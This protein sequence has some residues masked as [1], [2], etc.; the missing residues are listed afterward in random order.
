MCNLAKYGQRALVGK[1]NMDTESSPDYIESTEESISDT[2]KFIEFVEGMKVLIYSIIT[3]YIYNKESPCQ[4]SYYAKIYT[5][6]LKRID[7]TI[8]TDCKGKVSLYT[9]I[10][11]V[12][13]AV[14]CT[15]LIESF[16]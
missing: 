6:L 5:N 8:S 12:A 16:V 1:V 15:L 2:V 11:I 4:A 9:S 7:D 14:C 13:I 10:V 3:I